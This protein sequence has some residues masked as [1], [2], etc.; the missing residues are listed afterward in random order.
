MAIDIYQVDAF[1][2]HLFKGNPAA[3][4]LLDE[5]LPDELLKS[6]AAENNL[7]ETAYVVRKGNH[8]ELRWFTP[9]IEVS[10]C[11]H[12]TVATALVL[13]DE[14]KYENDLIRF[15]TKS[16]E[17]TVRKDN[18][19]FI[20]NFP[21][22]VPSVETDYPKAL[23]EALNCHPVEVLKGKT[24]YVVVV[25]TQQEVEA[26]QPNH[27]L[28]RTIKV[29]GV[30]VTALGDEVDF[31]SRFFAPGSGIDEDPVTGSAHTMLIP[32]WAEKLGKQS[33][34]AKQLSQR[35]GTLKCKLL[36]DRVEIGGTAKLYMK[37]QLFL[38]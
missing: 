26:I 18:N 12:A 29:R 31:V 21:T 36:G 37:G 27:A 7:S 11:G 22:N 30:V 35:G 34:Y 9:T 5:W 24:D 20:L 25:K 19:F 17:L 14:L 33:F 32:Y 16:G 15:Q 1:S 38:P 2:A 4:C 13:F 6:I 10:L 8:F 3:V 23:I 28:L